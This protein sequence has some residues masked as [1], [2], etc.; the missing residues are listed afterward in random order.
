[1]IVIGVPRVARE[2]ATAHAA[3]APAVMVKSAIVPAARVRGP[4]S[5]DEAGQGQHEHVDPHFSYNPNAFSHL[6]DQA[7]IMR[8]LLRAAPHNC[9]PACPGDRSVVYWR[10]GGLCCVA[11]C[12]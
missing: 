11:G 7:I 2:G 3:A 10:D 5:G 9:A 6:I 12:I 1:M 8:A 4:V